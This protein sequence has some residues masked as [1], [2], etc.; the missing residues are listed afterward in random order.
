[1]EPS[2]QPI[3]ID[4][5]SD[6]ALQKDKMGMWNCMCAVSEC[7]FEKFIE[8]MKNKPKDDARDQRLEEHAQFLLVNFNN[9]TKQIRRVADKLLSSIVGKFPHLLWSKRVLW[10]ML[11]ILQVLSDS[12][13]LDP[14]QERPT[15]R[16][17]S[18]PYS[19]ELVDTQE[20]REGI[21]KDFSM[22]SDG[23]LK[24]AMKWAPEWTT[25][26]IQEYANQLTEV[27]IWNHA[28]LSLAMESIMQCSPFNSESAQ[29][30]INTLEKRPKCIKN[31]LSKVI[32]VLNLRSKYLGQV[33]GML[34]V[35]NETNRK[36]LTER[37]LSGLT[38]ACKEKS[39]AKFQES[40]WMA[41]ALTITL[42]ELNRMLLHRIAWAPVSVFVLVRL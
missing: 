14:N 30:S 13:K 39:N 18:T 24:E 21:V 27:D 29:L 37:I 38:E 22:Y 41:T 33:S 34:M 19:I 40:L 10:T 25:S 15:L 6:S 11:D 35:D 23:I 32:S 16:I 2:L 17:P 3:I 31:D 7:V 20:A 1:M 8:V 9:P 4:Y 42:R 5:L 26:H 28:G 12:L 36:H